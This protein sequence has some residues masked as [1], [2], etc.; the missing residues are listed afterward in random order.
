MR[1]QLGRNIHSIPP[2]PVNLFYSADKDAL[3]TGA[4]NGNLYDVWDDFSLDSNFNEV[5][6]LPVAVVSEWS[7]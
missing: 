3:T 1:L 5:S 4:G 2:P 6:G 7:F